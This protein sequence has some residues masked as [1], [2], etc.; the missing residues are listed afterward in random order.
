MAVGAG[1]VPRPRAVPQPQAVRL[2]L[3]GAAC[4]LRPA[5]PWGPGSGAAQDHAGLPQLAAEEG[6]KHLLHSPP[7]PAGGAVMRWCRVCQGRDE[8]AGEGTSLQQEVRRE[9]KQRWM[10]CWF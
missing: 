3:P 2:R 10:F 5:D 4:V 9:R 8:D 1:T 7:P 6:E